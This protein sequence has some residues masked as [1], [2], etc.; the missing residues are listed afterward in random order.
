MYDDDGTAYYYR[1][2]QRIIEAVI[3]RAV[4]GGDD[5]LSKD[6]R[7]MM[8]IKRKGDSKDKSQQREQKDAPQT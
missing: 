6:L 5:K 3:Q 7:R 4:N 2:R 8:G 1:Q